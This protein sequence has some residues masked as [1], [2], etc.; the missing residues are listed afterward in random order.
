MPSCDATA[1]GETEALRATLRALF[2]PL[3]EGGCPV[4]LDNAAGTLVP[5]RVVDAVAGVLSSRGVCNSML[6][7]GW[8]REQAALKAAAHEGAALFVN[9]PGG[10][11]DMAIG[12]SATAMAFRLSAAVEHLLGPTD[13]IVVSGLEHV[14]K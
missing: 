12:P 11:A 13:A 1:D 7:Y 3:R 8:G 4:F 10:A 5:Q 2:P 6:S 9:A 14:C